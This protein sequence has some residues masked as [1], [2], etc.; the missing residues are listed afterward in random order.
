MECAAHCTSFPGEPTR[1]NSRPSFR[2]RQSEGTN[3]LKV[4]LCWLTVSSVESP[5][6]EM[7]SIREG[8]RTIIFK[9]QKI[10]DRVLKGGDRRGMVGL[11]LT[12][13]GIKN[14]IQLLFRSHAG[15]K[16]D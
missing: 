3:S 11:H 12:Y 7:E 13:T 9:L 16:V 4:W 2:G 15:Q 5:T 8:I 10:K 6:S 14:Y 1:D